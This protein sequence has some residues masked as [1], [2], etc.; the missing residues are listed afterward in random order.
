MKDKALKTKA[1]RAGQSRTS[2]KE[3]SDPIFVTSSFIFDNAS[4]ASRLF[5]E[6]VSGNV[7]SRF[8]NPTTSA[9]QRRLA[10]LENAEFCIATSSGMSAILALCL[11]ILKSGDHIVATR[12]LFGSTVNLFN[13]IL[14]KFDIHTSYL[15]PDDIK[16]FTKR[17]EKKAKLV[18]IESPSNPL[19]EIVDIARLAQLTATRDDCYLAVDN[20][21]CTPILQRPLDLGA[22]IVVH[23]STKFI[24]GQ[25]RGVG[26][27]VLTNDSAVNAAI[28]GFLRTAG[29]SMSPF[30]AWIF[31]KS[32]ETLPI[33]MKESC[34]S[35]GKVA[36]WLDE[37]PYVT[38]VYY[39]G[40]KHH[41]Q[42]ELASRQQSDYGALFSFEVAGGKD[43]AW[44]LID[45]LSIFSITANL[46]DA[47]STITHSATTT[48]SRITAE[49]RQ[50]MGITDGLIRLCIGLED[51]DDLISDLSYGLEQC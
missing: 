9:F 3:H 32:L 50:R 12:G 42:H 17:I 30:N 39:P 31:H 6:E 48:H 13:N 26:G 5:S 36:A 19:C 45:A 33:R 15:A 14:K 23:S 51:V 46:G 47:K 27:A 40:L 49:E 4:E 16:G 44:K 38:K 29:P 35:A 22:D 8:T 43:S 25:G 18:F 41:P 24:D 21:I 37:Y 28:Y 11:S 10:L 34:L 20:C 2:E 1:V 7:Y